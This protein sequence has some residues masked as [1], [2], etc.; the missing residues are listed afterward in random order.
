MMDTGT[1]ACV[2]WDIL[3]NG[4][5]WRLYHEDSAHRLDRF[6]EV[7]L[8]ALV[9]A[10][11]P[12]AF[13]YFYAFFRREAFDPGPLGLAAIL[14]ASADHARGVEGTQY[15]V[16]QTV[17]PA[18]EAA[19]ARV[20]AVS[21]R[22]A[23]ADKAGTDGVAAQRALHEAHTREIVRLEKELN[24]RV[25]AL[26]DLTAAEVRLVEESTKYRYGEV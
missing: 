1:A 22:A 16:D 15:I 26:F 11:D 5:L 10:E 20:D 4:R 25:Y 19:V 18:L 6:Y 2:G 21:G 23:G 13:L 3:T 7:D 17:V 8:P 9:E 14:G 12:A 24:E